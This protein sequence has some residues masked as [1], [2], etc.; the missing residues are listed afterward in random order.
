M[1][2]KTF[3]LEWLEPDFVPSKVTVYSNHG[4]SK[5]E[6]NN[7]KFDEDQARSYG[8][9]DVKH[10]NRHNYSRDMQKAILHGDKKKALK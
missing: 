4:I 8:Y 9:R 10:M 6:F 2:Q 5:K 7:E 3:D 1:K